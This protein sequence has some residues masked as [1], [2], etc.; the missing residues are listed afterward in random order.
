MAIKLTFFGH[1][2]HMLDIGGKKV[3]IDPFFT[4]N[5][6]TD[7][8]ADSVNPDFIIV[9]H[10]HFD[11]VEDLV[12]IAKRSGAQCISNFEI[13]GWLGS[14]GVEN[15][16][17][18]N[19]GGGCKHEF[20]HLKLTIAHHTSM[21][22]DGS[23]GGNPAGLL[24]TAEGKRLYFACDTALFTDMQLY[25]DVD[26]LV[27]PIGDNFTMGPDD[28]IQAIKWIKPKMVVPCHY[29]T[30]PPIKQD[31]AAW[32]KRVETETEAKPVVLEAGESLEI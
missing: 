5:P 22:P 18:Q 29:N 25:S 28:S 20:G 14:Q 12:S 17:S 31:A 2:T 13:V 7:V 16:Y 24:I 9:S 3:L 8:A 6:L 1:N 26:L 19:L 27:V 15:A 10:G 21:L 30:F 4:S 23:N 11:H 32:A